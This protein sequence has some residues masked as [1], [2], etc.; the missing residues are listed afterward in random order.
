MERR[1][2]RDSGRK[3]SV[4]MDLLICCARRNLDTAW[5]ER[6]RSLLQGAIDW[7]ALISLAHENGLLP[8]LCEHLQEVDADCVSAEVFSQLREENQQ[9]ALHV[10]LLSAEL[11]RIADNFAQKEIPFA[12][13]KGP[14]LGVRAYGNAALRE[15]DDLDI[16][17]PQRCMAAAHDEMIALGYAS[18]VVRERCA[19][20]TAREI[21]GEYV[22]VHRGTRSIAELHTEM[23]LRH[24]PA[25][26]DVEAMI[27]RG[28]RIVMNGRE[29]PAFTS[30]DELL[31]LA[32]HGAKDFWTRL[33][34]VA[35]FA[36]VASGSTCISWGKALA[37]AR[38]LKLTRM[39]MLAVWLAQEILEAELPK[40]I[41]ALAKT[42]R[43]VARIGEGIRACF[44][45]GR[46][47]PEG[48]LQRSR[49][50]IRMTESLND[51]LRYWMRLSTAP[52]EEDW[53]MVD[54][55]KPLER[56]YSL[57]RPLRL[58]RKYRS[59]AARS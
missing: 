23:T 25:R 4:E 38:R 31:M 57:L 42:G 24:F 33:I 51:G 13:Y 48:V 29:I 3:L 46:E 49:Y 20:E 32:V 5:S 2:V 44:L 19:T 36:E 15:F 7:P 12:P 58:W 28:C 53:N 54:V 39:L 47:L 26:P 45:E 17:V 50:R 21:P 27:Q 10:L 8:L 22:F 16:V 40:E 34:W 14:M 35:D 56:S 9:N 52:A 59:S 55:P 37:E 1:S 6:L 43:G 41:A 11:A 18:K 30:E